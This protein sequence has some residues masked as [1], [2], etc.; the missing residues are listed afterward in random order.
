VATTYPP[1]KAKTSLTETRPLKNFAFDGAKLKKY[2]TKDDPVPNFGIGV[3]FYYLGK[4]L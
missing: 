2:E 4:P 1:P 3:V